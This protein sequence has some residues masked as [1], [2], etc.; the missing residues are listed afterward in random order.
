MS[1][2]WPRTDPAE[3]VQPKSPRPRSSRRRGPLPGAP[4]G[5]AVRATRR[6][7]PQGNWVRLVPPRGERSGLTGKKLFATVTTSEVVRRVEFYFDDELVFDDKRKPFAT[8]IDLGPEAVP[9]VVRIVGYDRAGRRLDEDEL[10][11]NQPQ[12]N[13][14]IAIASVE[15][16]AEGSYAIEAQVELVAGR[17]LDRVEFYRNDRLAATMT[18]PPFRTVLPGSRHAGRRLRPHR[19]LSRG[20][21]DDRGRRV[22]FV[23][24]SRGRDDRQPGRGVRRRQRRGGQAGHHVEPGGLR[25]PRRSQPRSRSSASRSQRT[26]PW[27]WASLSTAPRACGP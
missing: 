9:H 26:S 7:A 18:R 4:A 13:T 25:P 15:A 11:I 3:G 20:R 12:R 14:E 10:P 5:L 2:C 8:R 1:S 22:P 19:R 17:R 6:R 24:Q 27:C 16:R 23:R 21:L